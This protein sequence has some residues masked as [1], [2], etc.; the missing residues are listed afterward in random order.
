MKDVTTRHPTHE[1]ALAEWIKFDDAASGE[2]AVKAKGDVYLPRPNPTDKSE[3]NLQRFRDYIRRAVYYGATGRT[4]RSLVGLAF[5][6]DP[7]VTLPVTIAALK[8]DV[9]G[10]GVTLFQQAQALL[11]EVM[12]AGRAGLLA[13]YPNLTAPASKAAEK[14][15]DIRPTLCMYRAQDVINWRTTKIGGKI[16]LSMVVIK[17]ICE[18][19]DG[20][21]CEIQQTYRVLRLTTIDA[22][23]L[24]PISATPVYAVEVWKEKASDDKPTAT[25]SLQIDVTYVPLQGNGTPWTEIPF[26]FVGAANNDWNVDDAPLGD[27]AVLNLAHYR[28]SADYED[29]VFFMGQPQFWISGLDQTWVAMLKEQGMYVGARTITPLPVGGAMGIAQAQPNTLAMEAMKSKE[30]QMAALGARLIQQAQRSQKTATQQDSEDAVAH[31]V[32]SLAAENV[33]AAY[34]KALGWAMNFANATGKTDFTISSEYTSSQLDAPTLTFLLNA[35]NAGRM[36]V[37]D[38]WQAMREGG[39][40]KTTRTDEE[41]QED[42]DSQPVAAAAGLG[43]DGLAVGESK[44]PAPSENNPQL[45]AAV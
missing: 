21:G 19:E 42:I 9:N 25:K 34:R 4:L 5:G 39:Y 31:S 32:L 16:V 1:Q 27:I 7:D 23:T 22:K 45:A 37:T 18:V 38:F 26:T 13:D 43:N 44:N 35:V 41:I 3:E 8:D 14:D 2:L 15:L 29:S 11:G 40:I 12:K 20:F 30:E 24:L 28:N 6:T 10:A 17:E 33:S 36:A